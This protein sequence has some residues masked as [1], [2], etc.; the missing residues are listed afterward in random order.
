MPLF[1]TGP[2]VV[3]PGVTNIHI[4]ALNNDP[5]DTEP[6]TVTAFRLSG[7][8]GPKITIF[9][10]Q[11]KNLAPN[12]R[13][14]FDFIPPANHAIEVQVLTRDV[15][16]LISLVGVRPGAFEPTNFFRHREFVIHSP[17]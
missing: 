11:T 2:F 4:E 12:T 6:V 7:T 8:A 16:V 14:D 9:G 3:A 15:D 10:P 17:R 13:V 1:S 5:N